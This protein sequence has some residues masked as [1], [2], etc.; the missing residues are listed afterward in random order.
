MCV[1]KKNNYKQI[2]VIPEELID[3]PEIESL[4]IVEENKKLV[5]WVS[6]IKTKEFGW[7]FQND[8]KK[9]NRKYDHQM[10]WYQKN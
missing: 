9:T 3:K 8:I 10:L 5:N 7:W 4:K 2:A 1:T 6:V